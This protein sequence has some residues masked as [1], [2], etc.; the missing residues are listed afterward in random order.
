[1]RKLASVVQIFMKQTKIKTIAFD[2]GGVIITINNDEPV[3]RFKEIG[4]ADAD[5]LLDPYKQSGFFGDLEEGKITEQEFIDKLSGHAGKQMTWDDCLYAWKGF[6]AGVCPDKLRAIEDLK[7]DGYRVVM[8]SNTNGFIQSWADSEDFSELHKP[9]SFYFDKMYRSY[10]MGCMKPSEEFFAY[11]LEHEQTPA[12][13][14][15][16]VDDSQNNCLAAEKMGFKTFCPE[17]GKL[18]TDELK[19]ILDA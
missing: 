2:L 10:E 8:V 18:W 5:K 17:N 6:V 13:N 9:V 7:K 4:V 14:I 11:V 3:R 15:L 1:M 16:F 19:N 12:E